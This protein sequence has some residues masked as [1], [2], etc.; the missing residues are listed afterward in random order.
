MAA[1]YDLL[2]TVAGV[3][4]ADGGWV[5][6]GDALATTGDVTSEA[7][8]G[9]VWIQQ[10]ITLKAD[11]AMTAAPKLPFPYPVAV[12]VREPTPERTEI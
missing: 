7:T 11:A 10:A 8:S 12:K 2:T 1:A 4:F 6:T 5:I 3:E 9:S